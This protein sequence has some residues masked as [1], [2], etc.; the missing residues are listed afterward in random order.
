[1]TKI[2]PEI[3]K[4]IADNHLMTCRALVNLIEDQFKIK[5]TYKT[6]NN[7][8]EEARAQATS[9]NSAKVEAVRSAVLD[10]A[11]RYAGKYL[12]I[13]DRE[14][15]AWDKLLTSGKQ[16]F[17][18]SDDEDK[19]RKIVVEGVKDRATASQSLQKCI[20]SVLEFAK[21][22]M[23]SNVNVSI[24]PDLSKYTVDELRV[25]R[26]LAAKS[27][28]DRQGDSKAKPT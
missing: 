13:L 24:K 18:K 22:P 3:E 12:A 26:T 21:P 27:R 6:V 1:M 17:P 8:Q 2:T 20:S 11:N 7:Y 28:G 19:P 16:T 10:D 5:V 14:I 15:E 4:F 25:L 9:I 23:E